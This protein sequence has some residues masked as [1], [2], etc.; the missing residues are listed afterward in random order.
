MAHRGSHRAHTRDAC[1]KAYDPVPT[2]RERLTAF[3]VVARMVV[4]R[5][6]LA[7]MVAA[8]SMVIAAPAAAQEPYGPVTVGR[9]PASYD[10]A[11]PQIQIGG[12]IGIPTWW[13]DE[14]NFAST[15]VSASGHI[16]FDVGYLMGFVRLGWQWHAIDIDPRYDDALYRT[17]FSLGGRVE[18]HNRSI[19]TPYLEAAFDF[20]WWSLSFDTAV[21]C[22]RYYCYEEDVYRFAPGITGRVGAQIEVLPEVAVEAGLEM[23]V[24]FEGNVFPDPQSWLAPFFG[25]TVFLY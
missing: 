18:G 10:P 15:G 17:Y 14:G 25:A 6:V 21:V 16:G 4:A 2:A 22:G 19:V 20:N 12:Q 7:S 13:T 1:P 11:R 8:G 5:M 24:T 23:A 9:A 3:R